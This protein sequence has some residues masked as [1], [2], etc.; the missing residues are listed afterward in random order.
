MPMEHEE[1]GKFVQHVN[2]DLADALAKVLM[3]DESH[4]KYSL[5]TSLTTLVMVL[6]G[7]IDAAELTEDQK[8][9]AHTDMVNFMIFSHDKMYHEGEEQE[10]TR[11]GHT[12]LN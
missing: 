10:D 6:V 4:L 9:M 2:K 12:T 7:T 8:C 5:I 1:L 3:K 11:P